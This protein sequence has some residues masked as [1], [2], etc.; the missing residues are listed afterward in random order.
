MAEKQKKA[1]TIEQ[2]EAQLCKKIEQVRSERKLDMEESLRAFMPKVSHIRID[3][4]QV[5][6]SLPKESTDRGRCQL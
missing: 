2:L 3:T 4:R 5:W 1:K 6:L